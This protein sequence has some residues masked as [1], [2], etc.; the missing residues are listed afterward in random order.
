LKF[1]NEDVSFTNNEIF[2]SYSLEPHDEDFMSVL[3]YN[4]TFRN[5][6]AAIG[7]TFY[8]DSCGAVIV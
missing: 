7:S 5:N 3:F 8:L 1:I 6:R 4:C 2:G